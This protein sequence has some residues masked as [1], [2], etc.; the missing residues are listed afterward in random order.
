V[1]RHHVGDQSIVVVQEATGP[2][3]SV[4]SSSAQRRR[5]SAA[6]DDV[7]VRVL[8]GLWPASDT[9]ERGESTS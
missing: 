6:D 2:T 9:G 4:T 3:V 8:D 7:R 1:Q 5:G